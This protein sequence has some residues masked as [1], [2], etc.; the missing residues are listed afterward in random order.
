MGMRTI[1]IRGL[2]IRRY[3][4]GK[5]E[6]ESCNEPGSGVATAT[7]GSINKGGIS[8]GKRRTKKLEKPLTTRQVMLSPIAEWLGLNYAEEDGWECPREAPHENYGDRCQCSLSTRNASGICVQDRKECRIMMVQELP[9]GEI[10]A[11]DNDLKEFPEGQLREL[12]ESIK[13]HGLLQPITVRPLW[14][15]YTCGYR[16]SENGAALDAC[17]TCE[18]ADVEFGYEV[19]AG[20]RRLRAVAMLGWKTVPAIERLLDD[21]QATNMMAA[22]HVVRPV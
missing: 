18:S 14:F 3:D 6:D 17:P 12:T 19:V 2:D 22:E 8:V 7:K 20:K 10:V 13:V 5:V 16:E 11:D 9:V 21:E 1:Y 4:G 15:C